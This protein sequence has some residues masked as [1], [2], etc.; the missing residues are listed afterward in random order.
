ML[1]RGAILFFNDHTHITFTTILETSGQEALAAHLAFR[2]LRK[3]AFPEFKY[4]EG[5]GEEVAEP[6]ADRVGACRFF[7]GCLCARVP[8][9]GGCLKGRQKEYH[10]FGRLLKQDTTKWGSV[11]A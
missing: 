10:R 7:G 9:F 4:L 5:E 11:R 3:T 1:G 2:T 6:L 8:C